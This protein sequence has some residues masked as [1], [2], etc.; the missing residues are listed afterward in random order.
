MRHTIPTMHESRRA[1]RPSPRLNPCPIEVILICVGSRGYWSV[2]V[3]KNEDQGLGSFELKLREHVIAK[4]NQRM[5]LLHTINQL[6]FNNVRLLCYHSLVLLMPDY[7]EYEATRTTRQRKEQVVF[8]HTYVYWLCPLFFHW[9][10]I[11]HKS[12]SIEPGYFMSK[13]SLRVLKVLI[14][15][16]AY[17][18]KNEFDLLR[19][20]FISAE[21]DT[22]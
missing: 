22:N 13:F 17:C 20:F 21:K 11:R 19:R 14:Y 2:I 9:T 12:K 5:G 7:D 8:I 6:S 1:T 16:H 3:L 15:Q 18:F 4:V 10:E